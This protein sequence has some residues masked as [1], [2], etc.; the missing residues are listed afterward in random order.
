[1]NSPKQGVPW[2]FNEGFVWGREADWELRTYL[3]LI[4]K[5]EALDLGIGD[6]H[7]AFFLARNGLEVEGID[8]S[9]EAVKKCKELAGKENLPIEARVAD[10]REF[11]IPKGGYTCIVC[12]Y[13]LPFLK[14]MMSLII[15][16]GPASWRGNPRSNEKAVRRN[17]LQRA[18]E[19]QGG[20]M[21]Q[22]LTVR[23]PE[24]LA[25]RLEEAA[26]ILRRSRSDVVRLALERFRHEVLDLEEN[27]K[28]L[29][30][31]PIE[32]VR[33]LLDRV[34]SGIPDLGRRH[35]EHLLKRLRRSRSAY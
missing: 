18:M 19:S 10:V 2:E 32:L 30:P 7:N 13:V 33:D 29:A 34:E 3:H 15:M 12:S 8:I 6:G 28:A 24:E 5:G 35:R 17:A 31:R 1:M 4:P 26:R 20:P 9:E 16:V 14:R 23:M 27:E 11:P 21:G 22:Q 25:A